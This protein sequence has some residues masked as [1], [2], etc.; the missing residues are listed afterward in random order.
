MSKQTSKKSQ[1]LFPYNK[2]L[3]KRFLRP[4]KQLFF[5][6]V[7]VLMYLQFVLFTSKLRCG[8][9]KDKMAEQESTDEGNEQEE[10]LIQITFKQ[11]LEN[12]PPGKYKCM[13]D[14]MTY[15]HYDHTWTITTP[16]I[17]LH[18]DSELCDDMRLF[19][20]VS[21]HEG[22]DSL[23]Q[24]IFSTYR[25]KNC[26]QKN[27]TFALNFVVC[28]DENSKK[29]I[30][31]VLKYGENPSFG[32][33]TPKRVLD[34]TGKHREDFLKGRR[35]ENQGLGKG[36]FTYY[37]NVVEDQKK[38]LIGEI[39]KAASILGV[40][41][42]NIDL[43]KAAQKEAQ[44]SKAVESIKDLIP[45]SLLIKGHNPLTLLHDA[46][47]QGI[48]QNLTD[49]ECLGYATSIRT[50]LAALCEKVVAVTNDDSAINAALKQLTGN[51][52]TSKPDV[53]AQPEEIV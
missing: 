12:V 32:P 7:W 41:Q 47:S 45:E 17:M 26:G 30:P 53:E 10:Y 19:A 29:A 28:K 11:F 13:P 43:M 48:H 33:P 52:G 15:S 5:G 39:I 34:M 51:G 35:C 38:T 20:C 49:E 8:N 23:V 1:V 37:R 24:N 22:T 21:K 16:E 9:N 4:N 36:A 44:F 2:H 40:K 27:K 25:C 31:H 46:L 18:C 14:A 6:H 50:V 3:R 42:E